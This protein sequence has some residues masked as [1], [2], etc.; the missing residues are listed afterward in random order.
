MRYKKVLDEILGVSSKQGEEYLYNC[1]VCKTHHKNKLSINYNKNVFKCWVCE[2]SGSD[3]SRIIRR[4]GTP[5][6]KKQ[7]ALFAKKSSIKLQDLKKLMADDNEEIEREIIKL[8][9]FESLTSTHLSRAGHRALKYLQERSVTEEDID[10]WKPGIFLEGNMTGRIIFLSFDN[11][12]KVVYYVGRSFVGHKLSYFSSKGSRN[13]IFNDLMIDWDEPIII[14]E[15]IFDAI[16]AGANA[17]PLLGSALIKNSVL[18]K[19]ICEHDS[20]VVLALDEDAFFKKTKLIDF[21]LKLGIEVRK[22]DI[23]PYKDVGEM[24]REVFLERKNSA[25]RQDVVGNKLNSIKEM[26]K[27]G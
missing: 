17:I 21:F 23:S 9:H 10:L 22:V 7:A 14:V 20:E 16:K 19:K 18:V 4:Y 12:G 2:W 11:N 13:I 25:S 3:L 15:G 27:R 26:L 8:E 5:F 6:Q 1:P 24:P